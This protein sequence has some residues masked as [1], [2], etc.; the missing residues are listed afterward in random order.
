MAGTAPSALLSITWLLSANGVNKKNK[1]VL[2]FYKIKL[3]NNSGIKLVIWFIIRT[4]LFLYNPCCQER[5]ANRIPSSGCMSQKD[6]LHSRNHRHHHCT[7][8]QRFQSCL[9]THTHSVLY[10]TVVQ[11]GTRVSKAYRWNTGKTGINLIGHH[12]LD[13]LHQ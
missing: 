12:K 8:L 2:L 5:L 1:V 6:F 9:A 7:H 3:R 4:H 10:W 13:S 11:M